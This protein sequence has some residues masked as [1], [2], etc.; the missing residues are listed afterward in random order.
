MERVSQL[1]WSASSVV[2]KYLGQ[3]SQ[4][5]YQSQSPLQGPRQ[6][7]NPPVE[8]NYKTSLLSLATDSWLSLQP[9]STHVWRRLCSLL[10]NWKPSHCT[11][12]ICELKPVYRRPAQGKAGLPSRPPRCSPAQ[13]WP[14]PSTCVWLRLRLRLQRD[15]CS[16]PLP[17][18][19]L[20]RVLT[21][22]QVSFPVSNLP[23]S[24]MYVFRC[25]LVSTDRKVVSSVWVLHWL[26]LPH[27][28]ELHMVTVKSNNTP[29]C[30]PLTLS[31][32]Y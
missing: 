20:F 2:W 6:T 13:L 19:P 15:S 4:G 5:W 9:G 32:Q 22:Q 26:P 17:Q 14:E 11:R 7:P 8:I 12:T 25:C 27:V 1:C 21:D 31:M 3:H 30:S 18:I 28:A 29:A 10:C 24:L 23:L 16:S